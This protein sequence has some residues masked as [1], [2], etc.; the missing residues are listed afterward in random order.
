LALLLTIL[1]TAAIRLRLLS[2]PLER[3]EGEYAFAGQ[4]ILQGHPPYQRLYNM[5]WPGTYYC[6]AL[7]ESIFGQTIEGIHLG[8]LAI[9]ATAIVLVF[10]ICRRLLDASAAVAAAVTYAI[11]SLSPATLGFAGHATH[12]VILFALAG[13]LCLQRARERQRL[14]LYFL[15]GLFAGLA[16]IMKQPGIVFTAFVLACWVW[17]EVRDARRDWG[18]PLSSEAMLFGPKLAA[19][20]FTAVSLWPIR[21][22]WRQAL[23]MGMVL[24]SGILAPFFALLASLGAT[25]TLSAFQLWTICY[26][27]HY[28]QPLN[29]K[30][31]QYFLERILAVP[32]DGIAFWILAGLG[33][34]AIPLHPRTRA[35]APFVLGLLIF[36]FIGVLPGLTFREHYFILMLPAVALLAGAAVFVVRQRLLPRSPRLATASTVVLVLIPLSTAFAM[37]GPFYL[38]MTPEQ[39]CRHV[40]QEN[41]FIEAIGVSDYIRAHSSPDDCIAIIG[42]EPEIYFYCRRPSAT[43]FIYM[44]SLLEKQPFARQF[45][46]QMIQEIEAAQPKYVIFVNLNASWLPPPDADMSIANWFIDYQRRQLKLVGIVEADAAMRVTYRWDNLELPARENV[47]NVMT[48][49]ERIAPP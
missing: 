16:P 43:G 38:W 40:Y 44:Y 25:H 35:A 39:A 17:Q 12:F 15:A 6:Y 14:S 29:T 21:R 10:L 28:G 27:Q 49:Y 19:F 5:K 41:P 31:L 13:I 24:V 20:V 36:S 30:S 32:G 8:V 33:L 9:N 3:D 37:E 48:V 47:R 18:Q 7:F 4:L 11:L 26:A 1:G 2:M 34:L 42:S 23:L 45:R 22:E 46:Q